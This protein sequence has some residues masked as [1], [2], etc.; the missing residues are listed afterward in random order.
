MHQARIVNVNMGK[1][2]EMSCRNCRA[3]QIREKAL[4]LAKQREATNAANAKE[5]ERITKA[6]AEQF[7]KGHETVAKVVDE[8]V[9]NDPEGT[10]DGQ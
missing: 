1:D 10:T 2:C 3:C 6:K 7:R 5:I 4:K 9:K 8:L